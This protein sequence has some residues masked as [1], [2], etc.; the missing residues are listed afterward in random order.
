MIPLRRL[1]K[2]ESDPFFNT[3]ETLILND[4]VLELK[5]GETIVIGEDD[6]AVIKLDTGADFGISGYS[7]TVEEGTYKVE[8]TKYPT[9]IQ[10][11]RIE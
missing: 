1:N 7:V 8:L 2:K 6:N 9:R 4:R 10:L 3:D 11:R 5:D